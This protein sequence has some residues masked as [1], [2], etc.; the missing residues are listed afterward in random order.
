MIIIGT[1][2]LAKELLESMKFDKSG[3]LSNICFFDNVNK[4]LKFLYDKFSVYNSFDDVD[5]MF[6]KYGN[7]FLVAVAN[8]LFRLRLTERL[9]GM[10]GALS[11]YVSRK[12][13]AISPTCKISKGS[14]VQQA[15]IVSA[16]A[17]LKKGVFMNAASIVGHDAVL[18]EYVSV[19]PGVK[20]LGNVEVGKYSYIGTNS[21][22]MPHVK[23]GE[24]VRVGINKVVTEDL[25]DNTKFF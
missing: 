1:S 7:E 4:D 18:H 13:T 21:V 14:I 5:E 17:I 20:I 22:I 8:P 23:I 15:C 11:N 10:G 19:G 6:S 16:D 9:E 12:T 25:P 3:L 2:G 24:K